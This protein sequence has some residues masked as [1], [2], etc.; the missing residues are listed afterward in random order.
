MFVVSCI[1]I[2]W[3]LWLTYSRGGWL[4]AA[5][6]VATFLIT[7]FW[8]GKPPSGA[9]VA[10]CLLAALFVP[11]IVSPD[12]VS[13]ELMRVRPASILDR[14]K[15]TMTVL[16]RL[17]Y[18]KATL[19][20]I[21]EN[22]WFGVGWGAFEKA[23]PRYMIPGGYPVKLAHNNYL[24]VWAETGI[25]GLNAFVGLWLVVVYTFWRKARSS[26]VGSLR[27]IAC[28]FGAAVIGFLAQSLTDFS[29]YL[30]TLAYLLFAMLGL[31]VAVPDNEKDKFSIRFPNLA[32]KAAAALVIVYMIFLYRSFAGLNLYLRVEAERNKAFP[33]ELA[34]RQGFKTDPRL[35]HAVLRNSVRL[36]RRSVQYFPLDS[37]SRHMLG[38][39]YLRLAQMEN[40]PLLLGDAIRQLER[41]AA[42]D[43]W[44]PYVFQSLA[45]AYWVA[46]NAKSEQQMFQKALQA[47]LQAAKNFPV[48]PEFH[49]KLVQIYKSLGMEQ[50]SAREAATAEELRKQYKEF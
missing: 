43:P 30:P 7:K 18:W 13:E 31:L 1:L 9:T 4:I 26:S 41:A 48:N 3:D 20:M 12:A 47:E 23:Y 40:A 44:S 21:R 16:Q 27:G 46:G 50:E 49:D 5:L 35:Q 22:M 34:R 38:D 37:D 42:L 25:I 36:L 45:V 17:S 33:T 11:L 14:I 10:L 6:I 29:L 39:S 19:A 24:Q 28:G 8:K 2:P 15:D 32:A